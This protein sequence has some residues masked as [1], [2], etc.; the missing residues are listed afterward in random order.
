[1]RSAGTV[2][3]R[4]FLLDVLIVSFLVVLVGCG[5][6]GAGSTDTGS[7]VT[8]GGV[9][10]AT[11]VGTISG[12]VVDGSSGLPLTGAVITAA[13]RTVTSQADGSYS[14]AQV[15]SGTVQV[16]GSA[17]GF[18]ARSAVIT[19]NANATTT[20]NLV[21]GAA[22]T[23]TGGGG[24]GS[25][26]TGPVISSSNPSNNATAVDISTQ[27]LF[28][29]NQSIQRSTLRANDGTGQPSVVFTRLTTP[30]VSDSGACTVSALSL[31]NTFAYTPGTLAPLLPGTR[32]A[33]T[34]TNRLVG[35]N[36]Q[37][38]PGSSFTFTTAGTNDTG[39]SSGGT[40]QQPRIAFSSPASGATGVDPRTRLVFAFDRPMNN[41]TVSAGGATPSIVFTKI[42]PPS[43]NDSGGTVVIPTD[44]TVANAFEYIPGT[45]GSVSLTSATTYTLF[46]TNRA[47]SSAGVPS[48]GESFT[49]TIR[50]E[51]QGSPPVITSS[52]PANGA[53]NV[54]LDT[55]VFITLSSN[56]D[57]STV[58]PASVKFTQLTTPIGDI[59]TVN[60][61]L[62]SIN[63][64]V[65]EL[66]NLPSPLAG[67]T[68]YRVSVNNNLRNTDG[69]RSQG[70]L[71][72]FR[73]RPASSSGGTIVAPRLVVRN[74]QGT[75]VDTNSRIIFS[76][77]TTMNV[78]S[79]ITPGN[80]V[81]TQVSGTAQDDIG[82]TII[83]NPPDLAGIPNV[84]EYRPGTFGGGLPAGQQMRLFITNRVLSGAGVPSDGESFT[85]TVK[86]LQAGVP[87]V[88][89]SIA[90]SNPTSGE[91]NVDPSTQIQ[92]TFDRDMYLTSA[93]DNVSA[94]STVNPTNITFV[95]LTSPADTD[96]ALIP[97]SP[98]T[99]RLFSGT[100]AQAAVGVGNPI[101]AAGVD[102]LV[103]GGVLG[104]SLPLILRPDPVNFPRTFRYVPGTLPVQAG[105]NQYRLSVT[106]GVRD[107]Q[108]AAAITTGFTF[109]TRLATVGTAGGPR[110]LSANPGRD[111][112]TGSSTR[113]FLTF[114]QDVDPAS[115]AGAL[116][117]L[118]IPMREIAVPAGDDTNPCAV[119]TVCDLRPTSD[120]V[121]GGLNGDPV[122]CTCPSANRTGAVL[123]TA[124]PKT[125]E[126]VPNVANLAS[127][128]LIQVTNRISSLPDTSG[129]TRTA[130]G[131][132]T[133]FYVR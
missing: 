24:G 103:P 95:R 67:D 88:G 13:G 4:T 127:T 2:R 115:F 112:F 80:V 66:I 111:V 107:S 18:G 25:S 82:A 47:L 65:Y 64:P 114:D 84:F 106:N 37:P 14:I 29:L 42:S 8:T 131:D 36:N 59:A 46:V 102:V 83:A 85:F 70:S 125:L 79:V 51:D 120:Q 16:V 128:V 118:A 27:I 33:L 5:G 68:L 108:G 30:S 132:S 58:T 124:D 109:T 54:D 100:E 10:A 86:Q 28:T 76:F 15:P 78:T 56:T 91:T 55:R 62:S 53:T 98:V 87:P 12:V 99:I 121:P 44:L 31:A 17:S 45:L 19:V 32:Y 81:L 126:V 90:N 40:V 35:T 104:D 96:R 74:P 34:I 43:V 105:I 52:N 23:S 75:D 57:L 22:A 26:G 92:F 122:T 117:P 39:G 72:E 94:A 123:R 1:M 20:C 93:T 49:F 130:P 7:T 63:P 9:T 41:A 21:L 11:G 97:T 48:P 73:T 69:V 129:V 116:G 60:V 50:S 61:S 89:P 71:I 101:P 6:G 110:L 119:V 133:W 113:I 38:S 77:D 3:R